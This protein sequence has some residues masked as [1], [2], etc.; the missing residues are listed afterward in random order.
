M[1]FILRWFSPV[2]AAYANSLQY[3]YSRPGSTRAQLTNVQHACATTYPLTDFSPSVW[4][5]LTSWWDFRFTIGLCICTHRMRRKG[6]HE[7]HS[8]TRAT[9]F[10]KAIYTSAGLRRT[11]RASSTFSRN[12]LGMVVGN[13]YGL[14]FGSPMD[15]SSSARSYTPQGGYI[16]PEVTRDFIFQGIPA[17]KF[18]EVLTLFSS[19]KAKYVLQRS[20]GRVGLNVTSLSLTAQ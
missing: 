7:N 8:F 13:Q 9:S 2:L 1:H 12:G 16:D 20:V 14:W 3:M 17:E 10:C 6:S 4:M 5:C 11:G 15:G 19:G 18:S